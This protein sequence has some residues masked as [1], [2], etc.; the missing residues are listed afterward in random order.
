MFSSSS[1]IVEYTN[2]YDRRTKFRKKIVS[3]SEGGLS[4]E[5]NFPSLLFCKNQKFHKVT[6]VVDGQIQKK[7]GFR[8]VYCKRFF[9]LE[10]KVKYQVGAE[11]I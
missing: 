7:E 11:F 10:S 9:N 6:I 4:F 3:L 8:I 2:P 1:A 5:T